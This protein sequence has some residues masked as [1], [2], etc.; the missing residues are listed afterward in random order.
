MN[1]PRNQLD[2]SRCAGLLVDTNLLVLWVVGSVNRRRI[3]TFKRTRQYDDSDY[4]LLNRVIA[5]FG[6]RLFTVAHVMAEVSNLTDLPGEELGRSRALLKGALNRIEEPTLP[7]VR[8][9]DERN[10]QTL[11]LADA[12]IISAAREHRCAV[13]TDDQS[14]YL[15]LEH[16]GVPTVNFTHLRAQ[17]ME[18]ESR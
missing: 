8:A 11:G 15:A 4:D 2:P 3:R 13:L 14:L 12:A 18:A 10:Y 5:D 7:S 16:E 17:E 9:A 1:S 6:R